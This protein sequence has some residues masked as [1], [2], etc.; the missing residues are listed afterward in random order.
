MIEKNINSTS[1][2]KRAR[3]FLGIKNLGL[4]IFLLVM[5][6]LMS[7][8]SPFFFT[9]SNLFL[10]LN[11]SATVAIAGVG[12]TYVIISGGVDLSVGG[13]AALAGMVTGICTMKLGLNTGLSIL[14]ALSIGLIFGA[15]NG[16]LI[17]NFK[18]QPMICTLGTLDRSLAG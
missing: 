18:L 3:K 1:L 5:W 11:Q 10:I 9:K 15:I 16:F 13:V 12:M 7:Q 2:Q 4:I 14:I 17:G 8:L 6:F